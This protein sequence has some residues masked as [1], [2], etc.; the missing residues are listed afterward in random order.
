MP[1]RLEVSMLVFI[2]LVESPLNF[3]AVNLCAA[4]SQELQNAAS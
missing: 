1:A 2:S 3:D 4:P